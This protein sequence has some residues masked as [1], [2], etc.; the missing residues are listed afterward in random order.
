MTNLKKSLGFS[1]SLLPIAIIGGIFVTLYQIEL[2][3]AEMFEP[4]ID[5]LG[6]IELLVL[7]TAA[8]AAL[9]ALFCGFAGYLL[10][11]KI[12]LW[13]PFTLSKQSLTVTVLLSVGMG[14]LFSLDYWTFGA[15]IPMIQDSAAAGMTVSGVIASVLYGGVIEEVMLRL[16]FLSLAAFLLWKIFFRK[17][18]VLTDGIFWI[19]NILAALL[20]AAGHLPATMVTFGAL[21]PLLVFRCLLLNGGF[22]L[23]FGWLYKKYGIGFAMLSHAMVHIVSKL[24]WWIFI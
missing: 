3:P 11:N 22:A 10:S 23:G 14:T 6:S 13:K 17:R 21:T 2:Y 18:E 19:A 8:Q 9:Y 4:V 20:F 16:F 12:G 15:E 7:I 24:I 5:Q 1:L